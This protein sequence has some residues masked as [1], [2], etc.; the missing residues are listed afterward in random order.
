MTGNPITKS[1]TA[2]IFGMTTAVICFV[3]MIYVWLAL[4]LFAWT[5]AKE[6]SLELTTNLSL[7]LSIGLSSLVA[8]YITSSLSKSYLAYFTTG[9]LIIMGLCLMIDDGFLQFTS[10]EYIAFGSSIFGT[11]VGGS[12]G[13][14]KNRDNIY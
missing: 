4:G 6:T 7:V 3:M 5:D 9:T 12:A 14:S 10:F 8:A 13:L 11:M 2:V 1:A